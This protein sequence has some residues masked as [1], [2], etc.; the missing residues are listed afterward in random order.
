VDEHKPVKRLGWPEEQPRGWL[1]KASDWVV[2]VVVIA[3]VVVILIAALLVFG[4][5]MGIL[6]IFNYHNN[7]L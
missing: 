7:N 3:I 4:P 2:W 6:P 5:Q 1:E